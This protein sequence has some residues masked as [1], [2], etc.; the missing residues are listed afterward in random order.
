MAWDTTLD[1]LWQ[2]RNKIKQ[3]KDNEYNA[4]E[5]E[6]LSARIVWYVDHRHELVDHHDQIL[7]EIDL[8][9]LNG[10]R[11]ETKRRR[12]IHHLDKQKEHGR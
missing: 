6:R 4:A 1:P 10:V 7:V 12:W 5:D 2:D 9:Q 8:I 11:R 3:K